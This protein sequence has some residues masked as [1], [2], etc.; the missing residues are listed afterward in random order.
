MQKHY[1]RI[2]SSM[3]LLVCFLAEVSGRDPGKLTTLQQ[4]EISGRVTDE[5][6]QPIPGI[7]IVEKGTTN[8][9]TTDADGKYKLSVAGSNSTLIFTFIGYA[10]Q[11]VLVG[12]QST[13]D[14]SMQ[15]DIKSLEEVVVTALGI[16]KE[17]KKLGYSVTSVKTDEL[18]SH[19]TTNIMESLEGKVAGLNITPPAAGAGSSTQ[20][21]LRGQVGFSGGINSPLIVVNGL[22]MNQGTRNA[23][24]PGEQ[25]DRGDN[26]LNINPDDIESMSVLKGSTA[27]ALYGSRA[28]AGAIIITTKSGSKNQGIGVEYTTSY[29]SQQPLDFM[30]QR[31]TMYGA[32]Q[33]GN[34]PISAADAA[35][36]SHFG[37][38]AKLDGS[39]YQIF[40]GE[41]V[42][43]QAYENGLFDYF[44]N[45]SNFTNTVALSKGNENGSFRV[46]YSNMDAKGIDPLNE[47]KRNVINVGLNQ[48]LSAKL[49]LSVNLNYANEKQINPPQIGTQGVG[50]VNFFWRMANSIPAS[51]YKKNAVDP[52]SGTEYKTNGFQ[53]TIVNPY[54]I[55]D[56]DQD[57]V[58][59]RDR[60][61]GT[62]TLRYD[63][64]S[65]LYAQGRFN[66]DFGVDITESKIPDGIG[67][68][69]PTNNDGTYKGSYNVSENKNIEINADF[70]IGGK[71]DF[72]KFSVDAG[73]GGNTWRIYGQN[74]NA[75]AS[76]FVVRHL[77]SIAN[78]NVKT[79]G[80]GS[81]KERVNSLY[82][83]AEV[84]YNGMLYLNL[85]GRTDWFS[86]LNPDHNSV[87]YPSVTGSFIF[88]EVLPNLGWLSYGK[89]RAA[90]SE[91]GQATG[92]NPYE[93]LLGYAIGQN[94]F[95]GQVTATV[96]NNSSNVPQSPNPFLT[97]FKVT[98]TSIGLDLRLFNNRL[99]VDI[100][101]FKKITTDQ[102]L[103]LT[104]SNTS[105]YDISKDNLAS[106]QN[107]GLETQISYT[108]LQKRNLGWTTSWNNAYLATKVLAISPGV[109]DYLLLYFNGTGSEFLGQIKYH[110]GLPMNQLY[111]RTYLRDANGNIVVG[112]NG[113]LRATP[114]YKPVGSS[115]P[116]FTG[117]W[118]NNFTYKG[119]TLGIHIDYKFGGT[120]LSSTALNMLR[121]G[122]SKA[123]LVG[124]REGENGIIFEGVSETTGLPNTVA[125]TD[126]QVFYTDYRNL[127]IGDPF[128]FKS[129]FVKLRNISLAYDFTS[130]VNKASY[131]NFV[132]GLS[133]SAS[134]RNVA[135]LYKD[136]PGLDPEAIQSSGDIRA[137]YEN[138]SLPT[139]R[140]YNI[141]L[142]VKF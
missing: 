91:T 102:I 76:N 28:A 5:T 55:L 15:P 20:I 95:N 54:Y 18:V 79:Q 52:V 13:V 34:K 68:S 137:G 141:T 49:K 142:N 46:S 53:G 93:G 112:D 127:Q 133:L 87:F 125:V 60:I 48:N 27:A 92:A 39:D 69:L 11:E 122:H 80:F 59:T 138:A 94:L 32:G 108:V 2:L 129:D 78:G 63:L 64:T 56:S 89:L 6:G 36:R 50:A 84:G 105:G 47:Y 3:L 90:W 136:L 23:E 98:E 57:W 9:T 29:T 101:A 16:K 130:L 118:S 19:R 58:N 17:A 77:Y 96:A 134:C 33:A 81:V 65:W 41:T 135:I 111:T 88:S 10:T 109:D 7:N 40:N 126:L 66:Y 72:G 119:L 132:K 140:N 117:G 128:I 8:G 30:D 12:S 116:K 38:G 22:P 62:T 1:F 35:S 123:S 85:T 71:K 97:P 45:G 106:L 120:V 83:M 21:R 14:V 43:Y 51:A 44:R 115:I 124:R 31:Q 100:E 67:T 75:N 74:I 42:K 25:R 24:G 121:Q 61:L 107:S 4:Q 113:R 110:V 26:L 139:T 82:G 70:L 104:L 131:L 37:W 114:D 99:N 73:F 103:P 86:K